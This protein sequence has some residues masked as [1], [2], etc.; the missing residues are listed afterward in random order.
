MPEAKHQLAAIMFT[1]IVGYTAIMGKDA[2]K[3]M[4]LLENNLSIQKPLIEQ[5]QGKLLKTIGDG[6]LVAFNSAIGAVKCAKEI[7]N[8]LKDDVDLNIRVGI[9]I[10]DVLFKDGDVFGDAVNIA[11]RIEAFAQ[12]G[13]IAVTEAVY[14]NIKNHDG[15]STE[16]IKEER[17]KNVE[18]SIKIYRVSDNP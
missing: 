15:I 18:E 5:H 16:F 8:K 4:K 12:E 1:D 17:L 2:Q 10:G 11:S 6:L 14:Q 13:E 9:H 3:A 7:Q